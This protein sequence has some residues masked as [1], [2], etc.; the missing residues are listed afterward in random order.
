MTQAVTVTS[1]TVSVSHCYY[2]T[3]QRHA[4]CLVCLRRLCG[5]TRLRSKP[6]VQPA[7]VSDG[8]CVNVRVLYMFVHVCTYVCMSVCVC[9][10][11]CHSGLAA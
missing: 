7:S 11:R 6:P 4:A 8:R 5:L 2:A 3:N 9:M 10:R 1:V